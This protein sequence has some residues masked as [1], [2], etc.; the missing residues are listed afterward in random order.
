M[1]SRVRYLSTIKLIQLLTFESGRTAEQL[2]TRPQKK[3]D[4]FIE[5]F[6][7]L[8]QNMNS[9]NQKKIVLVT[10]KI[11]DD[12]SSLRKSN[13]ACWP[14]LSIARLH[15]HS[16]VTALNSLKPKMK[17]VDITDLPICLPRTRESIF[18]AIFE[19][20]T[21]PLSPDQRQNI[22]WLQGVAGSGKT[23]IA[24]TLSTQLIELRRRVIIHFRRG[25]QMNKPGS[26]IRNLAWQLG[27]QIGRAHV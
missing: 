16:T 15:I 5:V 20:M 3:I 13:G 26:V 27:N 9:L 12:L 22:L 2:W 8:R 4:D 23:T 17:E 6:D 18:E 24:M 25:S 19:W 14:T 7:N 21:R 11:L 10:S 1:D